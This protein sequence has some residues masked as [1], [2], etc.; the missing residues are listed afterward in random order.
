M[1][2]HNIYIEFENLSVRLSEK[3]YISLTPKLYSYYQ[4]SKIKLLK[5]C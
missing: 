2:L 4:L 1:Y 5:L 3:E